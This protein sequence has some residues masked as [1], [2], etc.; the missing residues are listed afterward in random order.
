LIDTGGDGPAV[1]LLHGLAGHAGEWAET[2][3]ALPE[4]RVVAFDARGREGDLSRAAHVAEAVSVIEALDLAPVV[5]VG[6]SLGGVTAF[7]TAAWH[8]DLVRGLVIVEAGPDVP[9]DVDAFVADVIARLPAWAAAK[10]GWPTFDLD[11][12]ARTLRA[13]CERPWHAEWDTVACP[14]LVVTRDDIP[15]AGHDLHL[16]APVAFAALLREFLVSVA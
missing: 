2:A 15:G 7:L 5:L 9:E 1:L 3:A 12:M 8:P 4:Y 13:A 14:R 6:Q 11:V 16:D 10:P